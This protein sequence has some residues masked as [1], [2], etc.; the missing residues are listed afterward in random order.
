M[1]E[2]FQKPSTKALDDITML[3]ETQ[4]VIHSYPM[5]K[6]LRSL[7]YNS[8]GETSYNIPINLTQ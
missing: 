5:V 4:K 7:K 1:R 2:H 8:G 3:V 6:L